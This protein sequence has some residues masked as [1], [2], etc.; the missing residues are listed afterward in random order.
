MRK[1]LC[2]VTA[3]TLL[4]TGCASS[5]LE[6]YERGQVYLGSG[7]YATAETI[8]RQLGTYSD[9]ETQALY[10]AALLAVREGELP[11]ARAN[12]QLLADFPQAALLTRYTDGIEA[13][14]GGDFEQALTIFAALGTYQDSAERAAKLRKAIPARLSAR[15]KA[16]T[17]SSRWAEALALLDAAPAEDVDA[18]LAETCRAELAASAYKKAVAA[19]KKGEYAAAMAT[20]TDLGDYR[21]SA[22]RAEDCREKLYQAAVAASA[23]VTA[24]TA[25]QVLAQLSSL[26]A[27]EDCERRVAELSA[28][29]NAVLSLM[30][31]AAEQPCVVLGSY[32]TAESGLSTPLLWQVCAVEG[33][34]ALLCATVVTDSVT[35]GIDACADFSDAE[36]LAVLSRTLPD[37]AQLPQASCAATAYALAQGVRQDGS[38]L[39]WYVVAGEASEGH[40]R[41]VRPDGQLCEVRAD[42]VHAGLR[43]AVWVSLDALPLRTGSGTAEDP[44]R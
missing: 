26:G 23:S 2:F 42:D 10:A 43:P 19:Q 12:L 16:L 25:A 5:N 41:A 37:A 1:G 15:V 11:L 9:A 13:E 8:F 35:A 3:C 18:S 22:L 17:A 40:L 33:S 38:G 27:Y 28:R 7:D 24:A 29:W 14:T 6:R 20:Y 31:K 4:A 21:D 36:A 34:R 39:A 44:F 32:P 30:T